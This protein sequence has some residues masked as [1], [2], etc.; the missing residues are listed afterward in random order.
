MSDGCSSWTHIKCGGVLPKEYQ[1]MKSTNNISRTCRSC[2]ELSH[3]FPFANA[4]LNSSGISNA[5]STSEE[6][7]TV[8]SVWTEFDNI[9]RKHRGNFKIGLVNANSVRGFKFYEVITWLLSGRFDVLVISETKID[10]SFLDSQF[11]INGYRLCHNDRQAGGG[12]L[13]IYVRSDVRVRQLERMSLE[14][15]STFKREF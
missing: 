4:S 9:A 8:T 15:L 13:M 7:D 1:H 12:G 3:Q 11:H 10:A 5:G 2:S 14:D 6:N